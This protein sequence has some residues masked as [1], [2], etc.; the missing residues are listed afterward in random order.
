MKEDLE[1]RLVMMVWG[2]WEREGLKPRKN[3]D[4]YGP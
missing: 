3:E 2:V 4:V 1:I